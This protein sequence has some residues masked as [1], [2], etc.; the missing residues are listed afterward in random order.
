MND[1]EGVGYGVLGLPTSQVVPMN[2]TQPTLQAP[3][4]V[5]GPGTGLGAAFL[6]YYDGEYHVCASEGGHMAYSPINDEELGLV[7]YIR[8]EIKSD[9]VSFERVASGNGMRSVF[10]YVKHL[11][12]PMNPLYVPEN[13][14]VYQTRPSAA[15]CPVLADLHPAKVICD[16]AM[17]GDADAVHTLDIFSR[18][19]GRIGGNI[20]TMTLPFGGLY[21]AGGMGAKLGFLLNP[22]D[23]SCPYVDTKAFTAE[24][25]SKGR[26]S[27]IVDRVPLRLVLGDDV[28][29]LG[30]AVIASRMAV[31]ISRDSHASL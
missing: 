2:K 3:I 27:H 19:L 5:I 22:L 7:K 14:A 10:R 18:A 13:V 4:A 20:A 15:E 29:L 12:Q 28:G 16:L 1:F 11:S 6:V 31:R 26:V 9:H 25:F 30:C 17:L 23:K 8:R 24:V 21:V